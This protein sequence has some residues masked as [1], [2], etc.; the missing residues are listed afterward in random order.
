[1][2][3]VCCQWMAEPDAHLQ[4]LEGYEIGGVT[5]HEHQFLGGRYS[6]NQAIGKGLALRPLGAMPQGGVAV[7]ESTPGSALP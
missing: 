2:G 1:V 5:R 7:V 4:G 6:G 3:L